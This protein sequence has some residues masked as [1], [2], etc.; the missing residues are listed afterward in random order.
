[1]PMNEHSDARTEAI[2]A[3]IDVG[4]QIIG[5]RESDKPRTLADLYKSYPD[6]A[7][8][9]KA[10][11]MVG[12]S[13]K[14]SLQKLGILAPTMALIKREGVRSA[15]VQ[16]LI[17]ISR[18]MGVPETILPGEESA[19]LLPAGIVGIDLASMCELREHTITV[20]DGYARKLV[21]GD[22]LV[23]ELKPKKTSWGAKYTTLRIRTRPVFEADVFDIFDDALVKTTSVLNEYAGG[24]VIS[25]SNNPNHKVAQVLVRHAAE[26]SPNTLIR[27]MRL[28]GIVTE[29]DILGSMEWR[30]RAFKRT[31][32]PFGEAERNVDKKERRDANGEALPND[33]Q[34]STGSSQNAYD[35]SETQSRETIIAT[36]RLLVLAS[37]MAGGIEY[38]QGILDELERAENGDTS[39]DL[40]DLARRFNELTPD[41]KSADLSNVSFS[42][43][44]RAKGRRF[45]IAIPDGWAVIEDYEEK[46]FLGTTMRPFVAVPGPEVNPNEVQ[47]RDR[48]IYSTQRDI[49]VEQTY[50]EC[51]IYDLRWAIMMNARYDKSNNEGIMALGPT[52]VWDEEVDAVN[53]RCLLSQNE[54]NDGANGLEIY[55]APY[56]LDHG[57]FIRLVLTYD[58]EESVTQGRELARALARTVELD[59]RIVPTCEQTLVRALKQKVPA[60]DFC[61]MVESY[62]KPYVAVRQLI[63]QTFQYKYATTHEGFSDNDI[64]L[65][66][67]RGIAELDNRAVSVLSRIVD[68]YDKQVLLGAVSSDRKKML[69]AIDAFDGN[70]FPTPDIFEE[71]GSV[72]LVNSAHI[73]DPVEELVAVRAR[74]VK[75]KEELASAAGE[76][77]TMRSKPAK[78][79][80]TDKTNAPKPVKK[81]RVRAPKADEVLAALNKLCDAD[82]FVDSKELASALEGEPTANQVHKLLVRAFE[83][84]KVRRVSTGRKF[85]FSRLLTDEEWNVQLGELNRRFEEED[86]RRKAEQKEKR[87][88]GIRAQL[89]KSRSELDKL[90][91]SKS[92]YEQR[93][94]G[95]ERGLDVATRE[96][97][98]LRTSQ[99][100]AMAEV[101]RLEDDVSSLGFFAIFRKK[102]LKNQLE[103]A[104]E[105]SSKLQGNL[106]KA[107]KDFI[108]ARK[109]CDSTRSKIESLARAISSQEAEVREMEE[110][111]AVAERL[112][113]VVE[114][115]AEEK[116]QRIAEVAGYWGLPVTS[117]WCADNVSGVTVRAAAS[118][119][120]IMAKAEDASKL[121]DGRYSIERPMPFDFVVAQITKAVGRGA[122]DLTKTSCRDLAL[123]V[124]LYDAV[125]LGGPG[126]TAA[127]I[128]MCSGAKQYAKRISSAMNVASVETGYIECVQSNV[129]ARKTLYR[130]LERPNP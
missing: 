103:V 108:V 85:L 47:S 63:F 102:E 35:A 69:D 84:S 127:T 73:F 16:D 62:V 17:K 106:K 8:Q 75:A 2:Q 50:A 92:R 120:C 105:K 51:G 45:S 81:R 3:V 71:P 113:D 121:A 80:T 67:A 24:E 90:N 41:F 44:R 93:L 38:P 70:A 107:N 115:S 53:T 130:R 23:I 12:V 28:M 83:E 99:S 76:S 40:E 1:M 88:A 52:V 112:D 98:I 100:E 46:S 97:E 30:F 119:L 60:D 101:S 111:L 14:A 116:R 126:V 56:A 129:G 18:D 123:A 34:R 66:G 4:D 91:G 104:R 61:K 37:G 49:D 5:M 9:L 6:Q 33:V 10:G 77:K 11:S 109:H 78:A 128:K 29:K 72:L 58:G 32:V 124:E 42:Q 13:D 25:V 22:R 36:L 19:S 27:T 21:M 118:A 86:A 48:I 122:Y 59:K 117:K 43:C 114:L 74:I 57:D 68:A 15:D 96:C 39:V 79:A 94:K 26:L 95:Y 110:S 82:T 31:H 7:K 65:A 20:A 64:T 125:P 89:D 55:I 87:L 54:P